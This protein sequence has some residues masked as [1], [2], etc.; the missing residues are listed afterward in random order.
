MTKIVLNVQG[1]MCPRCEARVNE[2]VGSV[3]SVCQ[4]TASHKKGTVEAICED[5]VRAEAVKAAIEEA[6]YAVTGVTAKK[7]GLLGLWL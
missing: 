1:L 2:A 5:C 3:P 4:V 6:G 7:K